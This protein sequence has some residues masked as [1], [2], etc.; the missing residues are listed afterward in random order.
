MQQLKDIDFDDRKMARLF[1]TLTER[2]LVDEDKKKFLILFLAAVHVFDCFTKINLNDQRPL[3][4]Y[5]KSSFNASADDELSGKLLECF[6]CGFLKLFLLY[7]LALYV[8]LNVH[9]LAAFKSVPNTA[10][11]PL[12]IETEA[13]LYRVH[14]DDVM[15][16][17]KS[18]DNM[19]VSDMTVKPSS[20][21]KTF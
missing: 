20:N 9:L 10:I 8:A 2:Q 18:F 14:F 13:N 17:E 5:F 4:A 16:R 3:Y 1:R 12:E 7:L 6:I 19:I 11:T 15:T 21:K